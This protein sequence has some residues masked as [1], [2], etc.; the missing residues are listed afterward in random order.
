MAVVVPGMSLRTLYDEYDLESRNLSRAVEAAGTTTSAFVPWGSGGVY[1]ASALGV[2][3]LSYAPYYFFGFLSPLVLLVMVATGWKMFYKD[4]E[5][6]TGS[7]AGGSGVP[8][9]GE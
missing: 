2:P 3:V 1:M 8:S 9:T 4:S 6:P 7:R 5:A